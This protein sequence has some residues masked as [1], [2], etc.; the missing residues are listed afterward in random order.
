M[1]GATYEEL[2]HTADWAL[3]LQ[4]KDMGELCLHGALGMLAACGA[5]AGPGPTSERRVSLQAGSREILLVRWLQEVLYVLEV[6][7][8]LPQRM[9]IQVSKDLALS[10]RW[11]EVP[12]AGIDKPIKAVTYS[13]LAVQET[14]D[15]LEATVVFDV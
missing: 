13:G 4:G 5:R 7:H 12:L 3:R 11:Q 2:D 8:F 6:H 15:G 10:A 14:K 9:D 1:M